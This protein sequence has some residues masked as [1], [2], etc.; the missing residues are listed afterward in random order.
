MI[1]EVSSKLARHIWRRD[2]V[3]LDDAGWDRLPGRLGSE[4]ADAY[5]AR[6]LIEAVRAGV[7]TALTPHQR[8]VFE[9][10]VLDG[11]PLDALVAEL[12]TNRNAIYKTMFDTRRKLRPHL[13]DTGRLAADQGGRAEHG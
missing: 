6:D 11:I 10:L 8:R 12:D 9:A 3:R 1:L 4:P 2:R 5:E 7:Q 13:V